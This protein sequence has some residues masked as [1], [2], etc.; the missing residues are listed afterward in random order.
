MQQYLKLLHD[1]LEFGTRKGDRTGTGT[2]SLF[3]AH[4]RFDLSEG[5]PLVTTKK[6]HYKSII[7]ELLWMI[8][9]STNIN[10]LQENGVR[11]WNEWAD[12]KG[13]LGP[14]YGKQWRAWT[15][16][17]QKTID[18]LQQVVEQIKVNP[19]SRRLI[20]SAWNVNDLPSESIS[21]QEN[22]K[23]GK[24]ALAPCHSFFQFYVADQK[25]SCQLYQRSNDLFLGAPFNI[26]QYSILTMMV[27]QQCGLELGEFVHTIGD[28]HIYLDHVDQVMLQLKRTPK[29]KPTLSFNRC[30]PS[31]FEYKFEDFQIHGYNPDPAIKAR[32]SV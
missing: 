25:L 27:A 8:S 14:I 3:G 28:A 10:Y 2:I 19:N 20:V 26:C 30:P 11:I 9:G 12:E 4:L 24:M 23:N 15:V 13:E 31:L 18:Q 22:V 21:P 29:P 17:D 1:V 5:L 7:H 16:D 32:V 6:V